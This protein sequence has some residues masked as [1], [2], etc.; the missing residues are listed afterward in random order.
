[1]D[2]CPQK[3]GNRCKNLTHHPKKIKKVKLLSYFIKLLSIN[4]YNCFSYDKII[5]ILYFRV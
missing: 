4:F 1:M 5:F 2:L 3:A